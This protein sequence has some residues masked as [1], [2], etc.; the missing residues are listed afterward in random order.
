MGSWVTINADWYK[1]LDIGRWS[2]DVATHFD[3]EVNSHDLRA[4]VEMIL[5]ERLPSYDWG[6]IED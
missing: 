6:E 5:S 4:V 2:K 3:Y 1:A